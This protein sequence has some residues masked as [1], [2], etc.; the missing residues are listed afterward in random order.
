M[1]LHN[2][3]HLN[4]PDFYAALEE[5][6]RPE[7]KRRP[8]VLAE[9]GERSVI[10][11]VN[12]I[13]RK[14]GIL[15]GMPVSHARRM[16]RR[17]VAVSS[18]LYYYRERHQ[19][20]TDQISRFSPLVE[21]TWPGSY[22]LDITGT[23]RLFGPEPDIACRMEKELYG[24]TSLHARIGLASNRLVSQVAAS[25]IRP[26]DLSFIFPGNET[27]F[28]APLAISLLPGVG[29]VTAER[30]SGFNIKTIGQ[31]ASFP[32]IMLAEVFGKTAE[33]LLRA[34][35]GID[36][37]PVLAPRHVPKL[38]FVKILDRDEIDLKRLEAILFR[39]VED[40]GWSLR[41]HNRSPGGFRLEIRY[42]DGISAVSKKRLPLGA[43]DTDQRLFRLIL[44]VF[45]ELF[46]RRIALRRMVLEFLDLVMPVRQ[47]SLF[48]W[49]K[50][51]P[52]KERDLQKALDLARIKYGKEIISWGKTAQFQN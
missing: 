36:F 11:G 37:S 29:E 33:R 26:G 23:R 4:I 10:Q 2:I 13:A 43:I 39:Q 34:A 14:E 35:R 22:F 45:R 3:V 1:R 15:V 19:D 38:S 12:R 44:P 25:C 9:P 41:S 42:A 48:P 50:T 17:L 28:L 27:S 47:L 49:E 51:F 5:M 40:A 30:L 8:L 21:G 32:L 20:I 31:L 6:R 52:Q 24:K 16:C 7:L 18:D 46:S